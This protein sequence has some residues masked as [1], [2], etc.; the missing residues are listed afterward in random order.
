MHLRNTMQSTNYALFV[1]IFNKNI[2][3]NNIFEHIK[4]VI[5]SLIIH[6]VYIEYSITLNQL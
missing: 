5:K 2:A 6:I 4:I 3:N 1:R